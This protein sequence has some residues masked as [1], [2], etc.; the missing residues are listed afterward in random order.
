MIVRN[1]STES[2]MR[3]KQGWEFYIEFHV[4]CSFPTKSINLDSRNR[5]LARSFRYHS[6]ALSRLMDDPSDTQRAKRDTRETPFIC[7]FVRLNTRR[8]SACVFFCL[9]DSSTVSI[10]QKETRSVS[11]ISSIAHVKNVDGRRSTDR[12]DD[13]TEHNSARY[14][15][16][17]YRASSDQRRRAPDTRASDLCS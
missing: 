15:D 17:E 4:C 7:G 16:S 8:R 10:G 12:H 6:L 1:L 13:I 2:F 9:S 3:Q 14:S 5:R 11:T